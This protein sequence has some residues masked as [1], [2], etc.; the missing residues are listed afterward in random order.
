MTEIERVPD[1]QIVE[2]KPSLEEIK[3]EWTHGASQKLAGQLRQ[4]RAAAMLKTHYGEG[5]VEGFAREM[6]VAPTTVYEYAKTWRRL[7]EAFDSEHEIY[8]RLEDSPLRISNVIESTRGAVSEIPR[9][10]D[11]AEDDRLTANG[12]RERRRERS[13]PQNVE[14]VEMVACPHCGGVSKMRELKQWTEA[15]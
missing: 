3:S 9:S 6:G 5:S 14:T 7:L 10:L 13:E 1:A 4:A 11:E 15:V 12:Q 8:G 2:A